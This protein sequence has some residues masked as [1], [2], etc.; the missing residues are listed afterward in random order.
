MKNKKFIIMH[1]EDNCAT[2]LVDLK[3]NEEVELENRKIKVNHIIPLGHKFAL[4]NINKSSSI[5]KY[6]EIIGI[7]TEDIKIGDWIHTH[8][9][10]SHYLKE[11]LN[12]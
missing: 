11:I 7:A 3:E 6:G 9:M 8:N 10:I 5:K 4:A 12:L 1:Q 2:A